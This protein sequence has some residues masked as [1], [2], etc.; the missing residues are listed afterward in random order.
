MLYVSSKL[1]KQRFVREVKGVKTPSESWRDSRCILARI[2][3]T[4]KIQ[5]YN[6]SCSLGNP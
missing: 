1:H 6:L 3:V 2:N 5:S 4:M